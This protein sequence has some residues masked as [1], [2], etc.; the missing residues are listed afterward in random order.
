VEWDGQRKE[1]LCKALLHAY[2]SESELEQMLSFK[3]DLRLNEVSIRGTLWDTVFSL[4]KSAESQGR[5]SE[6]ISAAHRHNKGNPLLRQFH[7]QYFSLVPPHGPLPGL[8]NLIVK[9]NRFVDTTHWWTRLQE[10]ESQVC[11]LEVGKRKGTGF[12]VA[13][14]IVLTNYHV[15]AQVREGHVAPEQVLV[16][17]DFRRGPDKLSLDAGRHHRLASEW[18]ID[19]SPV[20]DVDSQPLPKLGV[21]APDHLDHA[22]IR[23]SSRP[24][25]DQ[26]GGRVRGFIPLPSAPCPFKPGTPLLI[27]QHPRGDPLQLALETNSIIGLNSNATRV[28]YRTNTLPGSSGAPCFNLHWELVAMHHYGDH[29]Y[30]EGIPISTLRNHLKQK[31]LLKKEGPLGHLEP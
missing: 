10:L 16:W 23:L 26:L 24:G 25:D 3:L 6:L 31:G 22:L 9:D 18:L 21:P 19:F 20:D 4:I 8:E 27:V 5:L 15:I 1:D 14:D 29:T 28:T 2:R 7:D 11:Q 30:N 13:P 17:F 12:L